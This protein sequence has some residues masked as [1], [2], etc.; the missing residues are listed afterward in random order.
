MRVRWTV[1]AIW[2]VSMVLASVLARGDADAYS[3]ALAV[4]RALGL[5]SLGFLALAL[6]VSPLARVA[7]ALGRPLPQVSP[8][9]RALG[10][11]AASG[12]LV[13]AVCATAQSPLRL[14]EQYA[15]P[16]LRWGLGALLVL[17][18]LALTSFAA[19][20]RRLRLSTWKELHRLAYAAFGC[21]ML[22]ALSM[23]FAWTLGLLGAC[24][25]VLTLGLL[26]ILPSGER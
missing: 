16:S 25:V 9:R 21:A 11:A 6:C 14:T 18:A 19:V 13:H 17:C 23:P 20:L 26:R 10:L 2:L 3:R 24:A 12:A 22:H 15:E 8:L 7:R 5:V 4:A 1:V